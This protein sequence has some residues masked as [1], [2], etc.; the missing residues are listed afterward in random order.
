MVLVDEGTGRGPRVVANAAYT[1]GS[2]VLDACY[3]TALDIVVRAPTTDAWTGSIS[4][5]TDAGAS[6]RPG[7]CSNCTVGSDTSQVVVDGNGDGWDHAATRCLDG[8]LCG[9]RLALSTT[10]PTT[11]A[12]TT[13]TP[14]TAALS[15]AACGADG[16][17]T[18]PNSNNMAS[19]SPTRGN[20]GN[21]VSRYAL[22]NFHATSAW[23]RVKI[24]YATLQLNISDFTYAV[25]DSGHRDPSCDDNSSPNFGSDD[26]RRV[27]FGEASDCS[28]D[29]TARAVVDFRGTPFA[30]EDHGAGAITCEEDPSGTTAVRCGPWA[31]G[32]W[33][34]HVRIHCTHNNQYC[35]VL[36]GGGAGGCFI[37]TGHLQLKIVDQ[38]LF[39][40]QCTTPVV[41]AAP[42]ARCSLG[43]YSNSEAVCTKCPPGTYGDASSSSTACDACAAGQTSPVG[44]DAF[45]D[46]FFQFMVGNS[47]EDGFCNGTSAFGDSQHELS[48]V[49]S[50]PDCRL[51]AVSGASYTF[52]ATNEPCVEAPL[53]AHLLVSACNDT[54]VVEG[55]D[56]ATACPELCGRCGRPQTPC[57]VSSDGST[58]RYFDPSTNQQQPEQYREPN[59]RPVCTAFF[60]D[61]YGYSIERSATPEAPPVCSNKA[62]LAE[63]HETEA[64]TYQ[65]FYIAALILVIFIETAGLYVVT[66]TSEELGWPQAI[67]VLIFGIRSFDMFSDWA[68]YSISLKEGGSFALSYVDEGGDFDAVS[69]AAL[70]FCIFGTLLYLPDLYG[71]YTRINPAADAAAAKT[72]AGITALVF[73]FEDLPQLVINCIYLDTVGFDDADNIAIFAFTMS[74]LSMVLNCMIFWD[75]VNGESAVAAKANPQAFKRRQSATAF[76]N[77]SYES[78]ET[79]T[80]I[81]GFGFAANPESNDGYVEVAGISHGAAPGMD[82]Y[83]EL[84]TCTYVGRKACGAKSVDGKAYCLRHLCPECEASCKASTEDTC[85]ACNPNA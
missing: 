78:A 1:R 69:S 48:L 26:C 71:F 22:G 65:T 66:K 68:F 82:M 4:L 28:G 50:E 29:P 76:K 3:P 55:R 5:S 20:R 73:V 52:N 35:I 2:T 70:A 57:V 77:P 17:Y 32:G 10:A 25:H 54:T 33:Q 84:D 85:P 67:L 72:A 42:T 39:D 53:C 9:I 8:R 46:C 6:Y 49:G 43:E 31:S 7:I 63:A 36:C 23:S 19:R 24:D 59:Y 34:V 27:R 81:D 56:I 30:I 60:C 38:S 61:R 51:F 41:G 79:V 58:V 12:P 18:L 80:R 15:A 62:A 47:T 14:T 83:E 40:R 44:S 37:G 21:C 13:A 64:A 75:E 74:M 16:Y 45:D 11:T